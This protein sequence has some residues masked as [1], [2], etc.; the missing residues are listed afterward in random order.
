MRVLAAL[1]GCCLLALVLVDAFNTLVL[2]R[3]T[4]HSFRIA[5]LYY[6]LTWNPFAAISRHIESSRNRE[7]FL[8]IYGPL[9]LIILFG[10]WAVGLTVG[11]GL[12]Q[13]A[14]QMQPGALPGTL[15]NDFYL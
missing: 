1:G 8:G 3:R 4:Q 6:W 12:I 13:W 10:V 2:A 11:F 15:A 7:A 14:A 9:S 5:R